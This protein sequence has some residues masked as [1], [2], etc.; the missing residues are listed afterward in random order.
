RIEKSAG[1]VEPT[2]AAARHI[3]GGPGHRSAGALRGGDMIKIG[4]TV[5]VGSFLA[6]LAVTSPGLTSQAEAPKFAA[7]GARL[8]TP[9]TYGPACS[10]RGWPYFE[11]GCLRDANSPS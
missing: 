9:R 10:E 5:L 3:N 7:K 2:A 6:G 8:D 1:S 4:A 11:I